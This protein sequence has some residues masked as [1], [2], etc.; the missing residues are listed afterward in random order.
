MVLLL[1]IYYTLYH[2]PIMCARHNCIDNCRCYIGIFIIINNCL[3][4]NGVL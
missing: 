3:L 4:Y 1:Y 2:V